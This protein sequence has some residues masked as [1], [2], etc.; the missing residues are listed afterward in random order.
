M[1]NR[2]R[3]RHKAAKEEHVTRPVS[4]RPKARKRNFK[5]EPWYVVAARKMSAARTTTNPA[6]EDVP[7]V[8]LALD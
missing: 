3:V 6:L 5:A 4:S 2:D 8:P 7:A 1:P